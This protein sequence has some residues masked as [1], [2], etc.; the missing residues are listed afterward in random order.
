MCPL[1]SG[2]LQNGWAISHLALNSYSSS[3]CAVVFLIANYFALPVQS[4]RLE[5][6][7]L[8]AMNLFL[9]LLTVCTCHSRMSAPSKSV[10]A[11]PKDEYIFPIH[12]DSS[13]EASKLGCFLEN[14]EPDTYFQI[15][16]AQY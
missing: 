16:A 10:S 3:A 8:F 6:V 9:L 12:P 2:Y 15:K 14:K 4:S 1:T 5:F 7:G 11:F 13:L